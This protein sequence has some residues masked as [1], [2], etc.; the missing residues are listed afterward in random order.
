MGCME[1]PF[2]LLGSTRTPLDENDISQWGGATWYEPR[3]RVEYRVSMQW[4][5]EHRFH[6]R[7][8]QKTP[9]ADLSQYISPSMHTISL[10]NSGSNGLL[11]TWRLAPFP[12]HAYRFHQSITLL[13]IASIDLNFSHV[14]LQE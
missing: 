10:K 13:D 9:Y 12:L 4:V 8:G 5:A 6:D 11:P 7:A 2:F 3:M 1:S 14:S